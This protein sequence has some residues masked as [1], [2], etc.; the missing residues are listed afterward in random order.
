MASSWRVVGQRQTSILSPSGQFEDAFVITHKTGAG[1]QGS[2]TIPKAQYS[3]DNVKR[4]IDSEA[5]EVDAV[6]ALTGDASSSVSSGSTAS[7]P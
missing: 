1:V 7:A 3:Q 5:A 6:H 2:V 4:L